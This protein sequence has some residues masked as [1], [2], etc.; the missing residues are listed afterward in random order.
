MNV[1]WM[2][3]H[4]FQ[5]LNDAMIVNFFSTLVNLKKFCLFQESK[6]KIPCTFAYKL[7]HTLTALALKLTLNLVSMEI[8]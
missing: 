3:K 8:L 4:F 2:L 7:N 1:G 5:F 6:L